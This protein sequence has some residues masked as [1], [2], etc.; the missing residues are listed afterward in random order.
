LT[1]GGPTGAG[2]SGSV[3]V[4][5]EAAG[6]VEAG[7]ELDRVVVEVLGPGGAPT[8]PVV[9]V[10]DAPDEAE[11]DGGGFPGDMAATGG[12]AVT[13]VATMHVRPATIVHRACPS[14][15]PATSSPRLVYRPRSASG[16]SS[17]GT[18]ANLIIGRL[19]PVRPAPTCDY[20]AMSSPCHWDF[21]GNAEIRR[22][23]G[24]AVLDRSLNPDRSGARTAMRGRRRPHGDR[25]AG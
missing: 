23:L 9:V 21:T 1:S 22:R 18:E 16:A 2:R 3:V 12:M 11:T 6:A 17:V 19:A 7:T 13:T 4:R 24:R 14:F 25:I 20:S 10:V 5:P 15:D 8:D